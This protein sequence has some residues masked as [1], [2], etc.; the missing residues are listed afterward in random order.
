MSSAGGGGAERYVAEQAAK[1]RESE[2]VA[3]RE[4]ADWF[5]EYTARIEDIRGRLW[6][7]WPFVKK[8]VYHPKFRGSFSIKSVMPALVPDMTYHGMEIAN[9]NEAGLVWGQMIR[10]KFRPTERKQWRAALLAYCRQDTLAMVKILE[11]LPLRE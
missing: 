5:P 2:R 10:D 6:D 4:L 9:G 11:R 3:S 1:E 8:Y 7:L